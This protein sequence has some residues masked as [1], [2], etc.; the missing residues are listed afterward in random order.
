MAVAIP[1]FAQLTIT[2][3][4]PLPNAMVGQS[5]NVALAATGGTGAL[6]WTLDPPA[7][8]MPS[9][10]GLSAGTINGTPLAS[11]G[12]PFTITVRVTD[13]ASPTPNFVS[14][15]LSLTIRDALTISTTTLANATVG[16]LYN[17]A[18]TATGGLGPYTWSAPGLPAGLS[19]VG[20]AI[21]GTPT[22]AGTVNPLNIAVQD[23]STPTFT[24]NKNFS[25]SVSA[26]PPSITTAT[27]LPAGTVGV[28]YNQPLAATGG[29][30]TG[31][32][33]SVITGSLP[34][35]LAIVSGAI[36]GTPTAAVTNA[37]FT[38]QVTDSA[39]GTG[40]KAFTL[41]IN[42]APPTI[43]TAT[44]LPSGTV[45]T[46]YNQPLAATGGSGT[47]YTYSVSVG[48][49]PAGL[50]IVSGAITGTP[51][52]AVSNA[53]FTIQVTD[54]ASATGT[55]A[56]TLTILPG[57]PSITTASPL[58]NGTV[59]TL[60]NQ[61][62]AATGG[63][64]TGYTYSVSA[65]SLPAGLSIVSGAITGTPTAAVSNASFTIQ[66][67]DSASGTGT[68]AFTLT[69]NAST[70][71]ITTA[72]P[73]PNGTIGQ[74]YSQT[75]NATGGTGT[76]Y[77]FLVTGGSLPNG[78]TLTTGGIVSGSPTA[79]VSNL[80]VTIQVTDSGS[81]T[82]T[83]TFTI[84]VV[85]SGFT[86]ST[87]ALPA[88]TLGQAYSQTL[89]TA[90]ASGAVTW[91]LLSG[92]T[93]PL[94]L[95]LGTGTGVI[96]GTP[97]AAGNVTFT[98]QA[99]DSALQ[100]ATKTFGITINAAP[101]ISTATLAGGVRNTI[102]A[103]TLASTGGTTPLTWTVSAGT[104][105][106]GLTL[107]TAGF[108]GGT[109]TTAG[110]ST[111]TVQVA[112]AAGALATRQYSLVIADA[113]IA[114]STAT[115]PGGVVGTAYTTTSLAGTG[116]ITPYVW[117]IAAGLLPPGLT[118]TSGGQISGT[119]TQAGTYSFNVQ[120]ADS[121]TLAAQR[122]LSITIAA[123]GLTITTA[124]PLQ[125]AVSGAPY[126][127]TLAA[128]GGGGGYQWSLFS[129]ALPAGLALSTGGVISGTTAVTGPATFTV[130]VT[131][132][133]GLSTTKA[134]LLSVS[135]SQLTIT[136]SSP[137]PDSF[138]NVA[139]SVT[140]QASG[141]SGAPYSFF[142]SSGSLPP[143]LTLGNSG[144]LSGTPTQAGSSSFTI[145]VSDGTGGTSTKPF[146]LAVN[147]P[148]LA[149]TSATLPPAIKDA[150]YNTTL[151]ASGGA[152]PYT[153]SVALGILPPGLNLSTA[154]VISGTPTALGTYNFT[155]R[156]RDV[157]QVTA[158]RDLSLQVSSFSITTLSLTD[159]NSG[160]PYSA[161]LTVIGGTAPYQWSVVSGSLPQGIT[162]SAAGQLSGTTTQQGTYSFTVQARDSLNA[163]TTQAL[164]LRV[165]TGLTIS[166][167]SLP[168]GTIGT[169]YSQTLQASGGTA[170][171][172]WTIVSGALPIGLSLNG[173]TG[174]ISGTP[175]NS[176]Q[177]PFNFVV[178]V[179]D[180][181]GGSAQKSFSIVIGGGS[182]PVITTT[183]LPN[184]TPNTAY[185]QTL[186]ATGG[187]T[188][189]TW[190]V[191]AG[192]LP[193]GLSL[194]TSGQITG[195]PTVA[196]TFNFTV[197]V[198]G[199]GTATRAFSITVASA[200]QLTIA[201]TTLQSGVVNVAY[202][203]TTLS[204]SGG[205]NTGFVW[206]VVSGAPPGLTLTNAGILSGTPLLAGIFTMTVQVT[207]S[208][209]NVAQRQFSITINAGSNITILNTSL[210][211]AS[212]STIYNQ[213]LVASGGTQPYQWS[214]IEGLLPVGL[215][216]SQAGLISGVPVTPGGFQFTV[217]VTD[218]ASPSASTSRVFLLS[219]TTGLSITS[220]PPN[221]AIGSNYNFTLSASGG[222]APF[223][224]TVASGS[225][226]P[227][228]T[229]GPTTGLLTGIP[230]IGGTY[231]LVLRVTD[232]TGQSA[233]RA[234]TIQVNAQLSVTTTA[235]AGGTVGTAYSQTL[236][237][238]GGTGL[239]YNWFIISGNL[240]GGLTINPST[241]AISGTPNANGT[242]NFTAQVNDS[243]GSFA[244]RQLSITIG[245][246]L[247]ITT[248]SL[249]NG[250]TS[251]AY[252][253]TV[254]AAGGI[255]PLTWSVS[256]GS[257]PAGLSLNSNTGT[258]SGTPTAGGSFTFTIQVRDTG[259]AS[260]TRQFTLTVVEALSITTPTALPNASEGAA[261]NQSLTA[262][263]GTA[264]YTWSIAVGV[265]PPGLSLTPLPGAITGT[266]S[267]SGNYS[268]ILQVTDAA[269]QT[270]QRAFTLVVSGRVT[271]VTPSSLPSGTVRAA[272][273]ETL[274]ASG[275]VQPYSWAVAPGGTPPIGITVN[276]DGTITGTPTS[277]GLFTFSVEV[278][279]GAG[280]TASRTFTLN[281]L[282]NLTITT[283]SPL[284]S[285]TAG[286]SYA[287]PL[288]AAGGQPPY[289]WSPISGSMPTGVSLSSGGILSGTP[290]TSG[291]FTFTAQVTDNQQNTA[292]AA[293]TMVVRLPSI[294]PVTLSGISETVQPAQQPR[295][296]VAIGAPFPV[297]INGTLTMTF[298]PDAVAPSDDP[299]VVFTNGRRTVDFV[300]PANATQAQLPEGFAMQT[301]TVAGSIS[302]AV[303]MRSGTLD[304]TPSPAP[305]AV[306]AIARSAPVIRTLRATRNATGLQVEMTG[307]ATS[308]EITSAVFRFTPVPGS[309]LQTTELTVS[310]SDGAQ[311]WYQSDASKPFGS[312]FT[313][314]QQ[315][316]VQGDTSAI[317]SVT[318]TMS[319]TQ[320]QSQAA[321][322]T[323][324]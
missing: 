310:L 63:S 318:V 145:Q 106:A 293:F 259:N 173:G 267:A 95:T 123:T 258:I 271:I 277:A 161:T 252:N 212:L 46:L 107:S 195:V 257:L 175:T 141:G 42:P 82:A 247:S 231:D 47:G 148:T 137:L 248:T 307:Y 165:A 243:A 272:Y 214:V 90:N 322:A 128:S 117:T 276:T 203:I 13:S 11:T 135:A 232:G 131:D 297:P 83:K 96:S 19:V 89:A 246:T 301:G 182:A 9:G 160:S 88:W 113:S 132:S 221:A 312:Q 122:T 314:T 73:L 146:S 238:T 269:Q 234:V 251:T 207:D 278:T 104:L 24:T 5:Y 151:S 81:T 228:L 53:S 61:P 229:L 152:Q 172:S 136:T 284:P 264:P 100:T 99:T 255:Q 245:S 244:S 178:Q 109:P 52:A 279:D 147:S 304:I 54:S 309:S 197:Q 31:Y 222:V 103:V 249:P 167:P 324:Q 201:A 270:A 94:G 1:A 26:G 282:Q 206:A 260:N 216:L 226:P 227:G 188:P 44:P 71:S 87:A 281:I 220:A 40:T 208:L 155:L 2:T 170:P 236:A 28:L 101:A 48:S 275:G 116:G 171:Y 305:S 194:S 32:S 217:R 70:L 41:T 10:M 199:G 27:P 274:S 169:G 174:V 230:T 18:L 134:F 180:N 15:A 60:Y 119:P 86:I 7:Q 223:T 186:A 105:P 241:G 115:L 198:S 204:A 266:P 133:L 177:S 179:N 16:V 157:N 261:F 193:T 254:V 129:G 233:T 154:G 224:W 317:S 138:L 49:L 253:Q 64:G 210:P 290:V 121:T 209:N 127:A 323:F 72:S 150:T 34:A 320:G 153:W 300:I 74:L 38:I 102:Y 111:F 6:T 286:S 313:L 21:T 256:A 57:S 85:G 306:G 65:G 250:A 33:Y 84:T 166:T 205:S 211:N 140:L 291:T 79:A 43:T 191:I 20:Q 25:L 218:A 51:N 263:G 285:G 3:P 190:T 8:T 14:K 69:I 240:P 158:V 144:L 315:F 298:T 124:S 78:L 185:N 139:Y 91:S 316:N 68:K 62:L 97:T 294:P 265:L 77:S 200:S 213:S 39:S 126:T 17:Q 59:G 308:R 295:V 219:V 162:L 311:R 98:V 184:A 183:S 118:L 35:G 23:S 149:I 76:G 56:F 215:T 283:P 37:S 289:S 239:G 93:L 130:Q 55:K 303:T 202:P 143:G 67:T 292:S 80:S 242:F 280:A 287:Q 319:N 120:V 225:L 262:T 196:N 187:T 159:A 268:F 299:A 192:S 181:A 235:L 288:A 296:G 22:A 110:T 12:S 237:A 321:S 142:V 164:T 75:I 58:P 156:V 50:S 163:T 30:G 168:A 273:S 125:Q 112:D 108:L 176:T 189:Y 45:G 4:S 36:A 302:L 29:S 92:N 114:V 66:V